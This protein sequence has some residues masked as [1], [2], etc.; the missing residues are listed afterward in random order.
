M[1]QL[2]INLGADSGF[3]GRVVNTAENLRLGTHFNPVSRLDVSFHD[4]VQDDIRHDHGTI[5]ASL[6][7]NRQCRAAIHFAFHIAIDVA[8]EMQAADEFDVAVDARL[9]AD[10][11]V[12]L[13]L[14][15]RF[16]FEH[17]P[18][19]CPEYRRSPPSPP[20]FPEP[21]RRMLD[22]NCGWDRGRCESPPPRGSAQI[23]PATRWARCIP[24]S[25]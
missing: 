5:D 9:G 17:L 10:Q 16:R 18:H 13:C 24:E 4:A 21:S 22:G 11:R 7:A 8:V 3:N 20:T 14:L 19:P 12:D 23:R 15:S 6:F 25:T 2:P 1:N